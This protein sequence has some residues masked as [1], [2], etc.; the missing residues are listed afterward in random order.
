MTTLASWCVW[1]NR[2]T[3][4]L[5]LEHFTTK[6]LDLTQPC[7]CNICNN[8]KVDSKTKLPAH[9]QTQPGHMQVTEQSPCYQYSKNDSSHS[10]TG[11]VK[12]LKVTMTH[13][14]LKT[15]QMY[16]IFKKTFL[17]VLKLCVLLCF[18]SSTHLV[19]PTELV[20]VHWNP[21]HVPHSVQVINTNKC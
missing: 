2:K 7:K 14:I 4:W 20:I 11:R 3:L 5:R 10:W 8:R 16:S 6:T 9:R 15:L 21:V 17:K 13:K 18:R 1:C 19:D 12:S